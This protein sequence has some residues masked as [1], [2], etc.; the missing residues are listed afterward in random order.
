MIG[1]VV[2]LLIGLPLIA[3]VRILFGFT[4]RRIMLEKGYGKGWFIAGFLFGALALLFTL[5]KPD[6]SPPRDGPP[7]AD[8]DVRAFFAEGPGPDQGFLH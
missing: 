8:A 4:M 1:A 3:A 2:C 7:P 5:C 6:L